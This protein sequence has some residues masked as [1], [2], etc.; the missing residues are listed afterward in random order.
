WTSVVPAG[1]EPRK[2]SARTSSR[3]GVSRFP[4][5]SSSTMRFPSLSFLGRTKRGVF[6]LSSFSHFPLGKRSFSRGQHSVVVDIH[7]AKGSP[8]SFEEI[9]PTGFIL[10]ATK[11]RQ[12]PNACGRR[13]L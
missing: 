13:P 12:E 3:R 7:V 6:T 1:C 5:R 8:E 4:F 11:T 2:A 9:R 10:L